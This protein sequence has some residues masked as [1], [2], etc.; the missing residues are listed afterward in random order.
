MAAIITEK[1]RVHNARQFKEDFGESASS[2][3]V[4]IGR[5]FDWPDENNPPAPA[6][7]VGEEIQAWEDM[8]ALKKVDP[9]DVSHGI[10]RYNWTSGTTYDEYSHD[11]S[12][13]KTTPATAKNNLYEAR[14]YVLTDE[15][16]VYKCIRT[17]RDE[18]GVVVGSINKPTGTDVSVLFE[19]TAADEGGTNGMPY[20][21]KYMYT[22]SASDTIKF[23]TNDFIPVKTLGAQA[24]VFGTH[25]N[26]GLNSS[27]DNDSSSQYQVETNAVDGSVLHIKV[28]NPGS[29]YTNGTYTDVAI[30]G[31]GSSGKCTVKVVSGGLREIDV[32]VRGVGYKKASIDV[33]NIT[34]IGGGSGGV[35]TPV[36]SPPFG[37]GADPVEELGGNFI[38]VNS[39]LEFAEGL[40]DFPT[41]NDFRRIGLCQ[42]PFAFGTTNRST[43]TSMK[44]YSTMTLSSIGSL[45]VDDT[46]FNASADGA[47]VGAAKVVSITGTNVSYLPIANNEGGY[48]NFVDADE[49]FKIGVGSIGTINGTPANPEVAKHTGRMMY[50]ENRGA[51][52]RA[53]DQIED[54]KLIIEM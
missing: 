12:A 5:S 49:I 1:F 46:V 23:V 45:T 40:G 2:T 17:G 29:G 13:T 28:D 51:V 4:F 37:H 22:I 16:H 54:I 14:F 10:T 48:V 8:L 30:D 15:Y 35:A 33:A 53:S 34:G 7:G 19:G 32:T 50:I 25:T 6:N 43:A 36:I 42:D 20:L 47:G 3:Y 27:A 38:I 9:A 39:R 26:G 11:Y 44:A 41:D 52:T 24:S 21:W 31:D 18:N